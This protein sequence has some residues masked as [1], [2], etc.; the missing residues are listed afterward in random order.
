M[1][2]VTFPVIVAV[3][4]A[5]AARLILHNKIAPTHREQVEPGVA[6]NMESARSEAIPIFGNKKSTVSAPLTHPFIA[7]AAKGQ[8][9]WA[10]TEE[11]IPQRHS[12]TGRSM[13]GTVPK[14]YGFSSYRGHASDDKSNTS[15]PGPAA[16]PTRTIQLAGTFQLPAVLLAKTSADGSKTHETETPV[17][18]AT[19]AIV[20][21]FY[22]NLAKTLPEDR[23]PDTEGI[24]PTEQVGGNTIIEP[25]SGTE[26]IRR[27]ADELYRSLF[28]DEALGRKGM[29]STLEVRLSTSPDEA[30]Q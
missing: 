7:A 18:S 16:N 17:E 22:R 1:K 8:V 20:D 23:S 13:N 2:P 26:S 6:E 27:H 15:G 11:S 24:P 28:G 4:L 9:Q 3:I 14:G 5:T 19:Q 12:L 25:D 29:E 21:N 30:S 10:S